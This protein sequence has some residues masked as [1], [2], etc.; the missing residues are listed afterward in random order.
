MTIYN[1]E[2]KDT[3][4]LSELMEARINELVLSRKIF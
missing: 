2:M 3:E 1:R 4:S